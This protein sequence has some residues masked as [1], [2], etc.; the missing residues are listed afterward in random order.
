MYGGCCSI[1]VDEL[2]EFHVVKTVKARKPHK[3]CECGAEIKPWDQYE[4]VHAKWDGQVSTIKTCILCA[5]IRDEYCSGGFE[6]GG[7]R[8]TLC[9]CLGFDYVT[10][11]IRYGEEEDEEERT[12][13][14]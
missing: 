14:N 1:E 4:S 2:P 3:C 9:E 11:Q 10:G 8:E 6:Y 7:L 13:N 5:K 12:D